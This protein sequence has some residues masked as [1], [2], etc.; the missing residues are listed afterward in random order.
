MMNAFNAAER[1]IGEFVDLGNK[2][3]W[4]LERVRLGPGGIMSQLTFSSA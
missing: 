3:G 1:T 4:K 2:S